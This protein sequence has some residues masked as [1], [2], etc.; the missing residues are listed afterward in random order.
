MRHYET[1]EWGMALLFSLRGSVFPKACAWALPGALLTVGV[2]YM[3]HMDRDLR[4][5]MEDTWAGELKT[6]QVFVAYNF[7]L[8]FVLTFRSTQA[9]SRWWEGAT[10]LLQARGEWFNAYSS[11]TAFC[12]TDQS[13]WKEVRS[14]QKILA[15][16]MSMLFCS[17]LESVVQD[18]IKFD[19]Y[20]QV[21]LEEESLKFLGECT[22]KCEVIVHWIQRLIVLNME[23]GVVPIPAPVISRVFQE[24]SRG[25]VKVNDV[26]KITE[27]LLPFPYV[28]LTSCMLLLNFL[29]TPFTLGI[30]LT[31]WYVAGALAFISIFAFFSINYIAAE[32]ESPFGTD[33]NDLPMKG[34]QD[35]LNRSLRMLLDSRARIVPVDQAEVAREMDEDNELDA[36]SAHKLKRVKS[37]MG[38][39]LARRRRY[40]F[41]E[42]GSERRLQEDGGE[43][44]DADSS[45]STA[46]SAKMRTSGAR[47][48][49]ALFTAAARATAPAAGAAAAPSAAPTAAKRLALVEVL[50]AAR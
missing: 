42:S 49:A 46:N 47:R 14:F 6:S 38:T 27:F 19:V 21:E 33:E 41:G 17:A 39:W 50:A 37:I 18:D 31:E 36:T 45:V 7:L 2:N 32:I 9:Y 28:Q 11:L 25:I 3:S 13:R 43:D 4:S 26:R 40:N 24:L 10:L 23:S 29:L 48:A 20:T 12:T 34:M 30:F 15:T 35:A 44:D 22:E 5:T 8:A 1:G 16:L